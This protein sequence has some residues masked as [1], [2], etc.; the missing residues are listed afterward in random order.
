[1]IKFTFH[2]EEHEKKELIDKNTSCSFHGQVM[3]ICESD[4][5][6]I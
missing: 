3:K 4:D 5:N 2:I 6:Y 1:M